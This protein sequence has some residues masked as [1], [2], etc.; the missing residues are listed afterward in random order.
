MGQEGEAKK[1]Q[2]AFAGYQ[3]N[4]SLLSLAK[5]DAILMHPLPAH[6]GQEVSQDILDSPASVVFD[7][8]E[9]RMHLAKALLA[10]MLGGLEIPLASYR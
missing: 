7:Q 4:S 8:A 9:N 6:R 5:G 3:V 2:R 10:E 1:R